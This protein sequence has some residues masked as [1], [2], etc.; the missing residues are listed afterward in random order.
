MQWAPFL[1]GHF[2]VVQPN[3]TLVI[4]TRFGTNERSL[5][6]VRSRDGGA[7]LEP[8]VTIAPMRSAPP[9]HRAPDIPTADVD[10]SGRVW[11]AW[12]GC[13]ART[14]CDG[15]DVLVSSSPDGVSWSP[16]VR[17]TTGR[18]ASIPA[19]AAGP[20]GR[21]GVVYYVVRAG[22]IDAELAESRNGGATWGAPQ[23]LN[24][25]TMPFSWLPNTSAGRMLADYVSLTYPA[26]RPL[27]V[28]ALASEPAAGG[29]FSQ[30]IFATRL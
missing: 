18:H 19:I 25:L 11:V 27:A 3:G 24:V 17:A 12:H 1:L 30:A 5:V 23:R 4:L 13:T 14:A 16:P 28:W 22:G 9:G 21:V 29:R 15:N 2:P 8:P 6:A 26:G 10:A 20:G 7:T